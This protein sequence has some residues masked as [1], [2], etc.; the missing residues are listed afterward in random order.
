MPVKSN[1]KKDNS[2]KVFVFFSIDFFGEVG[3]LNKKFEFLLTQ[4]VVD[5]LFK[6][7]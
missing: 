3:L 5:N 4:G 1:P 6:I 7:N 2:Q